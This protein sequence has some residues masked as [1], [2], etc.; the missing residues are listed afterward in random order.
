MDTDK[1]EVVY[2]E[3]DREYRVYCNI[4]NKLCIERYYRNHLKSQT[5]T[6]NKLKR[7]N[8]FK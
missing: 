8:H 7:E 1:Y 5:H 4:F 6:N 2:C 3:D